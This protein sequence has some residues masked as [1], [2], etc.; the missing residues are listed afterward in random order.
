MQKWYIRIL[1]EYRC[2]KSL[3][4]IN[5]LRRRMVIYRDLTQFLYWVQP[6][7]PGEY[8]WL[9]YHAIRSVTKRSISDGATSSPFLISEHI[10]KISIL[11]SI[12][13][14][15]SLTQ[16]FG[17]RYWIG[18]RTW[19]RRY[20]YRIFRYIEIN[21][22]TKWRYWAIF[23][24]VLWGLTRE[25]PKCEVPFWVKHVRIC[26]ARWADHDYIWRFSHAFD[27]IERSVLVKIRLYHFVPF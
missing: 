16:Q 21:F 22:L 8:G 25:G 7:H 26:R 4:V 15:M 18:M 20:E 1:K 3:V 5:Y 10:F 12:E 27:K 14:V 11:C 24:Q 23:N 6:T 19:C 17:N 13:D 2:Q 9:V